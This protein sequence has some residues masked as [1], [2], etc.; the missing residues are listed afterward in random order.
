MTKYE[1]MTGPFIGE[2]VEEGHTFIAH[3]EFNELDN[4]MQFRI[5]D[6]AKTQY[7][8]LEDEKDYP[9]SLNQ[10]VTDY[11]N[12]WESVIIEDEMFTP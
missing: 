10:L 7:P 5:R 12:S 4:D 11:E 6:W 9:I 8:D 1:M 3:L 2:I